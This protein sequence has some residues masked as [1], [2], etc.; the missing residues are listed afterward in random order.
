M[1]LSKYNPLYLDLETTYQIDYRGKKNPSPYHKDNYLVSA[2]WWLEGKDKF[3]WYTSAAHKE[4]RDVNFYDDLQDA[5]DQCNLLVAFNAKFELS[6]LKQ[7]GFIYNGQIHD[8]MLM[9]Y[10]LARGRKGE[11]SLDSLCN[12]YNTKF[13]KLGSLVDDYLKKNIG[14]ED[15]P[16]EIVQ[17]YGINDVLALKDLHKILVEE[18]NNSPHLWPVVDLTHEFCQCLT[19]IEAAGV[20]IDLEKLNAID[21]EFTEEIKSLKSTVNHIIV[22]VCGDT[23][24]NLDSPEQLSQLIYSRKVIDK[25]RWK[26]LFNLGAEQRG[27][28]K[29]NKRK[30]IYSNEEFKKLIRANTEVI[31]KT[32]AIHCEEC[33]GK[34]TVQRV[35]SDG[36]VS[37]RFNKCRTCS[38]RGFILES[39]NEVAGLKFLP[40]GTSSV[41]VGGFSVGKEAL[42]ALLTQARNSQQKDFISSL[43][44]ISQLEFYKTTF[45]ERIR[46]GL[47][48]EGLYHPKYMQHTTATGRL[49]SDLQNLPRADKFPIREC[50]ISRWENGKI[51]KCDAKQL[52]FRIAGELS[53]SE[54]IFEDVINKIDVHAQTAL[55]TGYNRQD[56]KPHTFAPV[57]GATE[58]GKE[59]A[60]AKYYRYFNDRYKLSDWHNNMCS[61][62]IK[63]GGL[64]R[65]PSGRE[66]DY[67]EV[68]RFP[69]GSF[70]FA[71][72]IKNYPVQA[73]ATADIVPIVC[74]YLWKRL[75]NLKSR[76]ILELHDDFP[77]DVHPDEQ[78]ILL[79]LMQ[80][81]WDALPNELI[82]RF[83]YQLKMPIEADV[84]LYNTLR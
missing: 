16:W 30:N 80:E 13:R 19:D 27:A 44:R 75:H 66:F 53:G 22:D 14:F 72:Q 52:E 60:I 48:D 71:T 67:G 42:S 7:C 24:V 59:E 20:K 36:T 77:V 74:I 63:S 33:H 61:N 46:Q 38:G 65:I 40:R 51:G 34:G 41:A 76:I 70:S 35:K 11:F 39:K 47:D 58:N 15:I 43:V 62:I 50:I 2:G 4:W 10:V 37:T 6:W 45:I 64:Y 26:Q 54:K 29:K 28:V 49:S 73:F 25:A 1:E 32:Q 78:E 23:P 56:S 81:A 18:L 17:E 55:H 8:P 9:A 83:N 5:L 21:E 79:Q 69:N 84:A 12:R 68:K 57:Y 82:R 3:V 31:K